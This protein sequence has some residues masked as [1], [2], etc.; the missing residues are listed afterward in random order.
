[1]TQLS[2]QFTVALFTRYLLLLA[3]ACHLLPH[4]QH[5]DDSIKY[6]KMVLS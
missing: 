4:W 6:K 3:V 5:A 1:M 2:D